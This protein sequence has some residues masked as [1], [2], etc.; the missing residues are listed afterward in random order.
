MKILF[1]QWHSFMNQGIEGALK[2]LTID[3]DIF[4]YQ[5]ADWETDDRFLEL[6]QKQLRSANYRL[7]LSVNFSPLISKVC[8][9]AKI[10]Y[11]AWV[12]DSPLHI[13]DLSA[14][15]N[16]YTKVYLFDRGQAEEF[17]KKGYHA[18]HLP[19]AVDP[20]VFRQATFEQDTAEYNCDIAFL[21][22]MYQTE[23]QY[24]K[25]PLN[26][27][28]QGYL[29]G[30]I[31][32]QMKIYGGYLIPELVTQQLLDKMNV[33]YAKH[34]SDGFQMGQQELEYMLACEVTGRE[35]Y[36]ALALLSEHYK[37]DL[38]SEEKDERLTYVRYCGY[39]D[40][41]KQMPRVFSQS[42]I[43]LNI[44]LKAIRTG[45]PL[46]VLDIMGCGG[47]VLTNYQEELAEY[48][49]PF[50]ECLIYESLEDMF[51]KVRF[52]ITHD[53]ERKRVANNGYEKV[54]RDFTFDS[55]IKT[56]FEDYAV[57]G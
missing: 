38:Y 35:R 2:R 24:F 36:I 28:L 8:E 5:F 34:A 50:E 30:I 27:Y 46:R 31:G 11:I 41:Y 47:F 54:K 32:A 52:Y 22:K 43:N 1:F 42:R 13:R 56:M 14:L 18:E 15:S 33:D 51:E 7:V 25:A 17:K 48:F 49:L 44:S 29:E 39:A 40:Y 26:E 57:K 16:S 9:E 45:I 19:L 23:Y 53:E 12:Y 4:F 55:R 21:G 10:S 6:F 3:Y 37:T 20:Q